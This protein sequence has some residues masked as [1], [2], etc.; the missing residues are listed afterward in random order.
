MNKYTTKE[1]EQELINICKESKSMAEACSKLSM[2]FNTFKK[3]AEKLGIYTPNQVGKG[4]TKVS[5]KIPLENIIQ[6]NLY[7]HYQSNKLRI[8]LIAEG[9]KKHQCEICNLTVWLDQ[10]IPLEL[11][12]IDGNNSNNHLSNLRLLCS[13]C[14]ALTPTFR[15]K[16]TKHLA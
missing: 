14:H 5:P 12:H 1:F 8:R 15:G 16:N 7:P 2:H 13:N 11:D 9:I 6:H 4:I 3:Y 10:P